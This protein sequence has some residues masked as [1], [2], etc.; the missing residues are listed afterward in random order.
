MDR[1][2]AM[3]RVAALMGSAVS[4]P[5]LS[6]LMYSCQSKTSNNQDTDTK[7]TTVVSDKHKAMI[8][9]ITELIIPK[10]STPGA[11]E[12]KVPEYVLIML[13]DC[14]PQQEQQR[15]FKGLDTLDERAKQA[16]GTEF[17]DCKPDQ[18][19]AL[20]QKEEE[21][22]MAEQKEQRKIKAQAKTREEREKQDDPP[23]FSMMKEM[24]IV[25]YFTSEAGATKAT[26]YVQVPG[27]FEACTDLQPG[28]KVW[29]T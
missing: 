12:A 19:V 26:A 17:V 29:A 25:G 4:A 3:L 8:E 15:F 24:T 7:T 18:Q 16:Y 22:A 13:A 6:G 5:L 21:L 11:K 10:T 23:F 14:Y 1:R 20:L 2:E 28:Q 27:R 9:E